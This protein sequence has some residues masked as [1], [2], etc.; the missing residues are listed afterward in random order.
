SDVARTARTDL[1]GSYRAMWFGPAIALLGGILLALAPAGRWYF[2]L[3]YFILWLAAPWIA[4][5]ISQPPARAESGLGAEHL[6]FLRRIA[7]KTW[8][9][10][11]TFV[12]AEENW[13]PPDNFQ[14]QPFTGVAARTSP[15]NIG[16]ALL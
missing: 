1:A 16:L 9:F 13:L 5:W 7:R 12:T 14:E 4:W 2:A 15:T 6:L 10:F 11:E 3:A 8:R